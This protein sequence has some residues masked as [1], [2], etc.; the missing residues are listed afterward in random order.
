MYKR[1]IRPL[2]PAAAEPTS[3]PQSE[4]EEPTD[5]PT[6]LISLRTAELSTKSIKRKTP[7][8]A[9]L[10]MIGVLAYVAVLVGLAIALD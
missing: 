2:E 9:R 7:L 1:Q 4:P 10:V 5:L 6:L 8:W 3:A